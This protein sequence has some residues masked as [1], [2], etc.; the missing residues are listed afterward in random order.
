MRSHLK[1]CPES[2]SSSTTH[3]R[4]ISDSESAKRNTKKEGQVIKKGQKMTLAVLKTPFMIINV[5]VLF[6]ANTATSSIENNTMLAPQSTSERHLTVPIRTSHISIR[7]D[8][9][10][11]APIALLAYDTENIPSSELLFMNAEVIPIVARV[12]GCSVP[13]SLLPDTQLLPV[14]NVNGIPLVC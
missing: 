6:A 12:T 3:F 13:S 8:R 9:N 14:D 5:C 2:H 10:A 7:F 1:L 4:H 11:D